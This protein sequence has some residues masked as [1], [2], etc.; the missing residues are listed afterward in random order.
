M[1]AQMATGPASV[2]YARMEPC[3]TQNAALCL[4]RIARTGSQNHESCLRASTR[5]LR[6]LGRTGTRRR[7]GTRTAL[8]GLRRGWRHCGRGRDRAGGGRCPCAS[9]AREDLRRGASAGS[10]GDVRSRRRDVATLRRRTVND[11]RQPEGLDGSVER[12][13]GRV[14]HLRV[15]LE[16]AV[17]GQRCQVSAWPAAVCAPPGD[18]IAKRKSGAV[19]LA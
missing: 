19:R 1:R 7:P 3:A 14:T 5:C 6:Q 10:H 11:A 16:L 18:L 4:R 15:G 8:R 12:S 2:S 13:D 17:V 9:R